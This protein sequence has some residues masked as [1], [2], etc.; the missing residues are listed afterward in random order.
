V[1]LLD[2]LLLEML[3]VLVLWVSFLQDELKARAALLTPAG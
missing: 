2:M 3:L 1:L